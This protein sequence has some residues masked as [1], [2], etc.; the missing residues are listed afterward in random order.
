[1]N[2]PIPLPNDIVST[3]MTVPADAPAVKIALDDKT[4]RSLCA[5][6][7]FQGSVSHGRDTNVQHCVWLA[8]ELMKQLKK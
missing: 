3:M 7:I 8:D 5:I 2:F 4:L 1:V 6:A